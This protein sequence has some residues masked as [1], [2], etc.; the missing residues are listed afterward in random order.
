MMTVIF[1]SLALLFGYATTVILAMAATFAITSAS[2]SF[3]VKDF[4][5]RRRYKLLQDLLWLPCAI[6]GSYVASWVGSG[7]S[8]WMT[9][10]AFVAVLVGV[11]WMNAW[12]MRQRGVPHQIV[13]TL[14]SVAGV[15]IGFMIRVQSA[16][17]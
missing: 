15:V 6:A 2:K 5:I 4:K 7:L 3:V 12:E 1:L 13:M 10:G 14:M 11:L 17:Q 9:G 16:A 8:Q